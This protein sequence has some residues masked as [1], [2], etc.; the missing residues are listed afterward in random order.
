MDFGIKSYGQNKT[1][2]LLFLELNREIKQLLTD[3]V[4]VPDWLRG[5]SAAG[6]LTNGR[7]L[8]ESALAK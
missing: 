3:Y 6:K 5:V 2:T 4:A 8:I 7:N 1:E